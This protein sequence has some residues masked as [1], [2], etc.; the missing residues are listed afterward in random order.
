VIHDAEPAD[1][2]PA[3]PDDE[4]AASADAPGE[5]GPRAP[6]HVG[7]V[8]DAVVDDALRRVTGT[9]AG[10][11]D[12]PA[13]RQ[14]AAAVAGA[15]RTN[16][17]LIV[18][19]GTGTGKSLGY[20]VPALMLGTRAVVATATKALQDQ[21][22]TRDLPVLADKLGLPLEFAVLKGRSNYFCRQRAEEVDGSGDQL[23]IDAEVAQS[24]GGAELGS[25]GREIRRLLE[26][27]DKATTGDRADLSWEPS[28]GAWA[29]VS[30]GPRDCPG[31]S[32][33]PAG[34]RC[35]AE[36]ARAKAAKADVVV[37]NTH[38][39]ATHLAAGGGIL[40]AHDL[41]IFDEA[42]ELEDIAS[43][44]LGF[45]LTAGRL[46]ALARLSKPLL[47]QTSVADAVESAATLTNETLVPHRGNRLQLPLDPLLHERLTLTRERLSQLQ[48]ALRSPGNAHAAGA[49]KSDD[50][51]RRARA[52]QA[53][54]HLTA[55]IDA[56][57]GLADDRVAWVEGPEHAPILKVAPVDVGSSLDRLLW[58][59]EDAPTAVLTSAT[60][61]PKL[62]ERIGLAAGSYDELDVGSPFDYPAQALLYCP[63]HLP[64][65]RKADFEAAM[66]DELVALIEAAG[67]RTMALFTS[68]R[69]MSAAA[70]AVRAR[71]PWPVLTQSDLPKPALV[72]RFAAEEQSCLF[73][74]MGFWQGVD[75]PGPALSLVTIDKLP[76]PRPDDPLL[77]ARRD[78]LGRAA[79]STIDVPRAATLLAQGVGRLIRSSSDRGVVAVLDNRLGTARYRWDLVRALPPMRR[80]RHRAEVIEFLAPLHGKAAPAAA[81]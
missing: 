24:A 71:V 6:G 30:V 64:D 69:A 10:S 13:Q 36:A 59:A 35:F 46:G 50:A 16:R 3:N 57:L 44:S 28:A 25:F 61:P 51:A 78:R 81:Q 32:K 75:V 58:H 42:H 20:L 47:V 55:D 39:Y 67:G 77:Q 27:G 66:V 4:P 45:E 33:C 74:T 53:L 15:I 12:R 56:V 8:T 48:A 65:P 38:L 37:V 17:H 31:A 29:Q 60:I 18:E 40:P 1:A 43:A 14:M 79:F 80:T 22:A 73:A 23:S 19:A 72:A 21:L 9:L 34:D 70:T 54:G 41:V 52:Q 11:E 2:R 26:W 68:W 5:T 7:R 62:G 63:L 49:D 76:F